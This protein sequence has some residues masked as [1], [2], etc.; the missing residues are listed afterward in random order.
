MLLGLWAG[1][2]Q[3]WED[4]PVTLPP[5]EGLIVNVGRLMRCIALLALPGVL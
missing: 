3:G 4:Q 5:D 1:Y 2:T